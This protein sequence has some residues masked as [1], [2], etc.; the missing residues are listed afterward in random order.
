M[1]AHAVK[2]DGVRVL[3]GIGI[4]DAI[5]LRGLEYNLRIDLA[6]PQRC[7]GVRGEKRIAR[8]GGED[9]HAAQLQ[10]AHRF[11]ADEGLGHIV[12]LDGALHPGRNVHRFQ[13]AL[14]RERIHHRGQ[15][16]HVVGRGA[17]HAL[18]ARGHAAPE[19]ATTHDEG[20][21]EAGLVGCLDLRRHV[22]DDG[23]GNIVMAARLS[24]RFTA[25]FEQN[26]TEFS[27]SGG[28]GHERSEYNS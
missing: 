12:H 15:H 10:M 20:D 17:L 26:A 23:R 6:G 25:E 8:A 4:V 9:D 3:V 22:F 13:H 16:A 18:V 2:F 27:R 11:A 5:H 14:H 7:G 19:V 28:V 21:F 24:Q 1:K